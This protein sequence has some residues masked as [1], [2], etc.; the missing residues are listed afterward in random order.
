MWSGPQMLLAKVSSHRGR[1]RRDAAMMILHALT[2]G[3]G[4]WWAI[5][6]VRGAPWCLRATFP[7]GSGPCVFDV[8]CDTYTPT[9]GTWYEDP[10][11]M[12]LL[13][14]TFFRCRSSR[15]SCNP[16]SILPLLFRGH[17][18]PGETPGMCSCRPEFVRL[19]MRSEH[20][21]CRVPP[22]RCLRITSLPILEHTDRF[23]CSSRRRTAA[24]R[25]WVPAPMPFC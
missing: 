22:H 12:L 11:A 23:L 20:A 19:T 25:F 3:P 14:R 5:V 18:S 17:Q 4:I 6:V 1:R 2:R 24:C 16:S 21:L 8:S 13:P 15:A 7:I 10:P 9:Y